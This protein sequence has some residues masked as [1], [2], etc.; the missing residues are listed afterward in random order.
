MKPLETLLRN[1]ARSQKII[2]LSEGTDSRIVA[3]VIKAREWN[4]KGR[5]DGV[6]Y[7]SFISSSLKASVGV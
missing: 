6:R 3:A 5:C 2:V 4:L 7:L 1:A